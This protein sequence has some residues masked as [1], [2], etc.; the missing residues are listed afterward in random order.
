MIRVKDY[1]RNVNLDKLSGW[2]KLSQVEVFGDKAKRGW[3][4]GGNEHYFRE[5]GMKS[6]PLLKELSE[7]YP[8]DIDF[9]SFNSFNKKYGIMGEKFLTHREVRQGKIDRDD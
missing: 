1:G 5:V 3:S 4:S 9:F 6:R 7:G 2:K 8:R